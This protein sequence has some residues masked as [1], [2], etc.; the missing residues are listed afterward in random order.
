MRGISGVLVGL[1]GLIMV[2]HVFSDFAFVMLCWEFLESFEKEEGAGH[3]YVT[4][5]F[6]FLKIVFSF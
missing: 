3:E 1:R 4:F 6:A 5:E 2:F